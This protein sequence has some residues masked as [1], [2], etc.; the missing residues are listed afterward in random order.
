MNQNLQNLS[1]R[2]LVLKKLVQCVDLVFCQ[3][4]SAAVLTLGVHEGLQ[5]LL[6]LQILL[7]EALNELQVVRAALGAVLGRGGSHLGLLGLGGCMLDLE[8]AQVLVH[9]CEVIVA[10]AARWPNFFSQAHQFLE[11]LEVLSHVGVTVDERSQVCV[12]FMLPPLC[13]RCH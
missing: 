11:V 4:G 5:L 7:L 12:L 10:G 13:R 9:L 2:L 6:L 3:L 1:E 8:L